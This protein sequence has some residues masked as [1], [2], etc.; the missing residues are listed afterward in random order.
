M[1]SLVP[2]VTETLLGWDITPV[3]VTR[4][5]EQPRLQA[6]GGTK[7]PDLDAIEALQPDL[8]VMCRQENRVEDAVALVERG[9]RVHDISPDTVF[10]VPGELARL[11][12]AVGIES[13]LATVMPPDGLA[14]LSRRVFVPIWRRPWMTINAKTYGSSVLSALGL[15]NVYAADGVSEEGDAARYPVT[16]LEEAAGRDPDLVLAPSEPYSF[17]ERHLAELTEVAPVIEVDGQDLFW[18]GIRTPDALQRLHAAVG[19][20][21]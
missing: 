9:L 8:V 6:V 21:I 2:S 15:E 3:A 20:A 7:N 18:W 19:A 1:A 11:A 17:K 13:S 4:F 5:C 16:T 14:P 10:D 12:E